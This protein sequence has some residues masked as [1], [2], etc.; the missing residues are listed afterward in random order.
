[1][2]FKLCNP[3]LFFVINLDLTII[4]KW[5]YNIYH[6]LNIIAPI[7]YLHNFGTYLDL[8]YSN[9]HLQQQIDLDV[10]IIDKKWQVQNVYIAKLNPSTFESLFGII[11]ISLF[12]KG[13][14]TCVR[15]EKSSTKVVIYVYL[16]N[17]CFYFS[18]W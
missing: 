8:Q 15:M 2:P 3:K 4:L 5:L 12:N 10:M 14:V 6:I 16:A 7:N 13:L 18:S 11:I 17:I 9:V 1:M